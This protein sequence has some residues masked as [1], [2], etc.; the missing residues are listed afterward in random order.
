MDVWI[1][2]GVST[3]TLS[4]QVPQDMTCVIQLLTYFGPYGFNGYHCLAWFL[5]LRLRKLLA[6]PQAREFV[7]VV[8]LHVMGRLCVLVFMLRAV[9]A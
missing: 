7:P 3:G 6:P 9:H 8:F 1:S 2:P 5:A 4:S